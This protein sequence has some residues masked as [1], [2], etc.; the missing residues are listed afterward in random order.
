MN[1]K[2]LSI[3]SL[4]TIITLLGLSGYAWLNLPSD[5]QIPVHWNMAGEVDRYASKLHGLFIVPAIVGAVSLLFRYLPKFEPRRKNLEQSLGL[6]AVS[7]VM[8]LIVLSVA[9]SASIFIALGYLFPIESAIT[10]AVAFTLIMIGNFLGK[11]K[12]MFFIGVRTPWTL[13]SEQSWN[14]SNRLFGKIMVVVGLATII[15]FT[16][17]AN[18]KIILIGMGS[19]IIAAF[20]FI[21]IYSYSVWKAD[22]SGQ[23]NNQ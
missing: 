14:K 4:I 2:H 9:H 11:S 7:W 15:S 13:S 22:N 18:L 12:S 5:A 6:F 10:I 17:G 21:L 8:M 20:V 16:L 23:T 1:I 3:L 19:S